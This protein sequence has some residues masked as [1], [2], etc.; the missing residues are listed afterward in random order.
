VVWSAATLTRQ[1]IRGGLI[2]SPEDQKEP[3]QLAAKSACFGAILTDGNGTGRR[4]LAE[5]AGAPRS[6]AA[7]SRKGARNLASAGSR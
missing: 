1:R 4:R 5:A 3:R 6:G 2:L 7:E